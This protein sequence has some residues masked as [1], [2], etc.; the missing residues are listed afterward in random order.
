MEL[1]GVKILH[2]KDVIL[3]TGSL[4]QRE[5]PDDLIVPVPLYAEGMGKAPVFLG[6][7]FADGSETSFRLRVPPGTRRLLLDP[8]ET[9]LRQR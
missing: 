2:Q 9:L 1:K 5:A 7:V 3:A 4:V 8:G 6:R